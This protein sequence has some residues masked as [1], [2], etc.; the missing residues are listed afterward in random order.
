[1]TTMCLFYIRL[2][3]RVSQKGDPAG[4]KELASRVNH[5]NAQVGFYFIPVFYV[6]RV[7]FLSCAGGIFFPF[8][9]N[10]IF[11]WF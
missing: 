11:L 1:M 10:I 6:V 7:V 3:Q 9:F 2:L 5:L 4:S 8:L